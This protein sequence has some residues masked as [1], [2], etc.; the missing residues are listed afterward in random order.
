MY[1]VDKAELHI[2][3]EICSEWEKE[4]KFELETD[5][6]SKVWIKDVNNLLLIKTDDEVKTVGGYLN[7]GISAKGAWSINNTMIIV[8]K[9]LIEYFVNGT[10]VEDTI[11]NNNDIFDYQIIAKAGSKFKEVYQIVENQK[12]SVQKVNRVY[13]TTNKKLGTLYKVKENGATLRLRAF[14]S[15]AS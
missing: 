3:D 13:A 5:D 2:V 15:I 7:Y 10:P 9:A 14:L 12:V 1:S 11:A 6:I 4:T 8:K